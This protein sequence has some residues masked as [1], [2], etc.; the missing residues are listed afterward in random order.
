MGSGWLGKLEGAH[1]DEEHPGGAARLIRAG[2]GLCVRRAVATEM[3]YLEGLCTA[4]IC[5]YTLTATGDSRQLS[6]LVALGR[7]ALGRSARQGPPRG[8][9]A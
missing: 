6:L 8:S 5:T 3:T 9:G 4:T 1:S 2:G 7:N